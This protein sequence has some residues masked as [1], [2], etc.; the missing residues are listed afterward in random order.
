MNNN[1]ESKLSKFSTYIIFAISIIA[2]I[3]IIFNIFLFAK[4]KIR[5]FDCNLGEN[6]ELEFTE[7][8]NL[9]LANIVYPSN[10]VS[11]T[12]YDQI[13]TL[14][15]GDISNSFFVR[16]KAVYADYNIVNENININLSPSKEWILG[17]DGYYYLQAY[18]DDWKEIVFI[19][20]I[21][22][23]LIETNVKNN[24]IISLVF[25]FLDSSQNIEEIWSIPD[26]FFTKIS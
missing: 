13:V 20:S 3:S 19:E 16:A 15:S 23:P 12:N 14:K 17:I 9:L 18:L 22:L 8:D 6:I 11:G 1:K 5:I 7:Q 10:I 2:L 24:T 4:S 26:K 25:E 21:T